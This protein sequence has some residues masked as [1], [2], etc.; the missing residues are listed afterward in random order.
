MKKFLCMLLVITMLITLFSTVVSAASSTETDTNMQVILGSS[1]AKYKDQVNIPITFKGSPERI[2][3]LKMTITYDPTQ[4]EYVSVSPGE[5][6]PSPVS[7]FGTQL[8]S[9]GEIE[10]FFMNYTCC[11]DYDIRA[12]GM[13]ANLTF[14]V[15]SSSNVTAAVNAKDVLIADGCINPVPTTIY[16]GSVNVFAEPEYNTNISGDI[17]LNFNDDWQP[18]LKLSLQHMLVPP[19]IL[20]LQVYAV[21]HITGNTDAESLSIES[22]N[23]PSLTDEIEID[24]NGNFD[25]EVEVILS[26]FNSRESDTIN[27]SAYV[28]ARK[29][30]KT[31]RVKIGKGELKTDFLINAKDALDQ[32]N[33]GII[34]S[35]DFALFRKNYY[36]SFKAEYDKMD[37]QENINAYIYNEW[38]MTDF[39]TENDGIS[40]KAQTHLRAKTDATNITLEIT[41]NGNTSK[42]EY[43]PYTPGEFDRIE[44]FTGV[45]PL[46]QSSDI[47]ARS[48]IKA[49]K[50]NRELE[51]C[52]NLRGRE[53]GNALI[54]DLDGNKSVNS[55][56][57]M[58]LKK[59]LVGQINRLPVE[60]GFFS[61]D[62]NDDKQIDSIDFA[63]LRQYLLGIIANFPKYSVNISSIELDELLAKPEQINI[64]GVMYSIDT[65][66]GRDFMPICPPNGQPLTGIVDLIGDE[67]IELP[68]T[69]DLDRVWIINGNKVWESKF[70]NEDK[71]IF[72]QGTKKKERIIIGG[73]KWGP[74]INVD[75]VVRIID[76]SNNEV[77]FLRASNQPI[78]KSE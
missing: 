65:Y 26:D 38:Y 58:I 35:I 9:P 77:Y 51:L 49:Y 62:L 3:T 20:Y 13:F 57:F 19:D 34:S 76:K 68:E 56:D 8:K 46:T 25:K 37:E 17:V 5:I 61:A 22:G 14:N 72:E 24:S 41:N 73:P 10:L 53:S 6:I 71:S 27:F 33:D 32:D 12:E 18:M 70:S 48:S 52:S 60:S 1:D 64:N 69:V 59:Y 40:V 2:S 30:D 47:V 55:I 29:G 63:Y 16:P 23:F 45:V 15:V 75:V 74:D 43:L 66:L 28:N 39:V 54:G 4:L 67:K 21:V 7:S 44:E 31:V 50:G 11:T 78:Y 36:D 42:C